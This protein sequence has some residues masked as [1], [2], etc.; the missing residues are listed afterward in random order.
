MND[1]SRMPKRE[2]CG[3]IERALGVSTWG[4]ALTEAEMRA[5]VARVTVLAPA[6]LTTVIVVLEGNDGM[7][8]SMGS[9][10]HASQATLFNS[11]KAADIARRRALERLS[12]IREFSRQRREQ[13]AQA[14]GSGGVQR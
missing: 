6:G 3:R 7:V 4:L 2:G 9:A 13:R 10:I 12:V 14:A 11:D 1:M 8:I 5:D